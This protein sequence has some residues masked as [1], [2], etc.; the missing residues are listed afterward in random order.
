MNAVY[1][2]WKQELAQG[3][4]NT[5][6]TGVLKVALVDTGLYTYS[7]AHQFFSSLAGVAGTPQTLTGKTYV[8]GVLDAADVTFPAVPVGPSCEALVLYIDTGNPAT[9]PLVTYQD[10]G[11]GNM[12]VTPNGGD[13]VTIWN[14]AGIFAL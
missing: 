11:I 1:P 13:L 7:A 8:N 3:S 6:L 9:S 4:A 10:T 2:L 5:A 14:A 12:P